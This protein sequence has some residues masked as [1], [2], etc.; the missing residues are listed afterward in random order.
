VRIV[1]D[2]RA[3]R[4]TGIE[5]LTVVERALLRGLQKVA[6]AL[7]QRYQH[8]P[9]TAGTERP[10]FDQTRAPQV[11]DIPIPV[12]ATAALSRLQ[13]SQWH[14]AERANRRHEA[15]VGPSQ[16]VRAI[17]HGDS[18]STIAS[19]QSQSACEHVPRVTWQGL[20]RV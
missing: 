5:A 4:E 2:F 6:S 11:I 16:F 13:V 15:N 1:S 10:R 19:G 18:L 3:P 17:A 9:R 14:R 7:S 12:G 20:T 8:G